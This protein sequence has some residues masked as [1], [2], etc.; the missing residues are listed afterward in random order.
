MFPL[1]GIRT[2]DP[3]ARGLAAI[4]TTISRP[5]DVFVVFPQNHQ[6]KS[7]LVP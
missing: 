2:P 3:Q 7:K 4:P 6:K 1:A 5:T